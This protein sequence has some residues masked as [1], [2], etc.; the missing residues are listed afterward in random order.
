MNP[1]FPPGT[2]VQIIKHDSREDLV[3]NQFYVTDHKFTSLANRLTG[4]STPSTMCY[5]S[6]FKSKARTNKDVWITEEA[7]KEIDPDEG[8]EF[9]D[10]WFV[11]NPI[12]IK[13]PDYGYTYT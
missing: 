6:P 4:G 7:L 9:E 11:W 2:L 12:V 13:V 5:R 1:K 3:G 10:D 8:F